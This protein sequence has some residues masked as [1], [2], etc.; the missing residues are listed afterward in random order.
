MSIAIYPG[1]FPAMKLCIGA[2]NFL[3]EGNNAKSHRMCD[4]VS[5]LLYSDNPFFYMTNIEQPIYLP[6]LQHVI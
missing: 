3:C 4:R 1:G 2:L 6:A 5:A